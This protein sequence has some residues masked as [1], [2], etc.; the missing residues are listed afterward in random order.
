MILAIGQAI[1]SWI[2]NGIDDFNKLSAVISNCT[3]FTIAVQHERLYKAW[4]PLTA[5]TAIQGMGAMN[6]FGH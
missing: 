4:D 5:R 6:Y 1:N 3:E 2:K